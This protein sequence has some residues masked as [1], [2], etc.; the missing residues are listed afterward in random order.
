MDCHRLP[1]RRLLAV[2]G[3]SLARFVPLEK[4]LGLSDKLK[5]S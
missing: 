1:A 2:L 5:L 3:F 4:M